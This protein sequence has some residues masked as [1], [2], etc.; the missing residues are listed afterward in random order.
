MPNSEVEIPTATEISIVIVAE[1]IIAETT[2]V[3]CKTPFCTPMFV[4]CLLMCAF[5][6][7]IFLSGPRPR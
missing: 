7:F 2:R 3:R 5:L 4:L 1:P 6:V